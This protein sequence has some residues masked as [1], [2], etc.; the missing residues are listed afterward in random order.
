[1]YGWRT[2][3]SSGSGGAPF[4]CTPHVPFR[5][6]TCH[7]TDDREAS[8]IDD[9]ADPNTANRAH[10]KALHDYRHVLKCV[11]LAEAAGHNNVIIGGDF[12][13]TVADWA[14][15][16]QR[17]VA[18]LD[19]KN[20][21]FGGTDHD[22]IVALPQR[23][24]AAS[25]F[26]PFLHTKFPSVESG[27]HEAYYIRVRWEMVPLPLPTPPTITGVVPPRPPPI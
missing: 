27:R 3:G 14:A 15:L 24:T 18:Q 16:L 10:D 26:N 5:L 11:Q 20:Y 9:P 13:Q 19:C 4:A 8:Y 23:L 2:A 1:M 25:N 6:I 17:A 21:I 12:C 22:C 7:V